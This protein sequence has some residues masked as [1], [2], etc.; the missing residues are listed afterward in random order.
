MAGAIFCQVDRIIAPAQ[1]QLCRTEG[2]QKWAGN[3]PIFIIK[4]KDKIRWYNKD[5]L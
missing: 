1:S 5:G 4:A 2:N 3:I